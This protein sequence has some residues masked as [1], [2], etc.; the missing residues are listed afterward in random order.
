MLV[1]RA[2]AARAH[3]AG[4]TLHARSVHGRGSRARPLVSRGRDRLR[5]PP[6]ARLYRTAKGLMLVYERGGRAEIRVYHDARPR[7]RRDK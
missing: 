1:A 2:A 6:D 3:R 4:T 5:V 7:A